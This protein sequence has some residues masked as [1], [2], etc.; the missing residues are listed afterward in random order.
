[1]LSPRALAGRLGVSLV[2]VRRWI[3]RGDISPV[4]RPGGR[5]LLIPESAAA[6][7]LERYKL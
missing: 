1:M 5:L 2:T 7:F 6:R 3:A 4:Y